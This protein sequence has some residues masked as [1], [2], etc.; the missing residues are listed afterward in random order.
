[1]EMEMV[2]FQMISSFFYEDFHLENK[3]YV[4]EMKS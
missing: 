4:Y 3:I 2:G 1:M